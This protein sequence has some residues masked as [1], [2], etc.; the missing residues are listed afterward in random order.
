MMAKNRL[1]QILPSPSTLIVN[2]CV[3]DAF[4]ITK[5]KNGFGS[6]GFDP[7]GNDVAG[8]EDTGPE[9][10]APLHRG[11]IQPQTRLASKNL[12]PNTKNA[13][14]RFVNIIPMLASLMAIDERKT[15]FGLTD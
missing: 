2:D 6:V 8:E 10:T 5:P 12:E 14:E 11:R 13:V 7:T 4:K 9:K 15:K 1:D 3:F